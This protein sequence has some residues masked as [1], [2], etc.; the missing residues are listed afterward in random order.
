[1]LDKRHVTTLI[2]AASIALAPVTASAADIDGSQDH[3]L[4]SQRYED[5]EIIR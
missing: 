3:P 1:M 5:S 4:V 2:L